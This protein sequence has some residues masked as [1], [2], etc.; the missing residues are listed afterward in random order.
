MTR[1]AKLLLVPVLLLAGALFYF[2]ALHRF[3]DGDEGFYLLASRLVL[4]HKKAVSGFFL[5]ASAPI[6]LH[7]RLVDEVLRNIVGLGTTIFRL[8]DE[9][10]RSA[11]Y[12]SMFVSRRETGSPELRQ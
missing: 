9:P 12:T 10:A 7:L 8:V 4:M 5:S 3:I 11:S 1:T 6:A 2:I